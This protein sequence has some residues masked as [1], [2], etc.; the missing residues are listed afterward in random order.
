MLHLLLAQIT[1]WPLAL[2]G[3]LLA[4][5]SSYVSAGFGSDKVT[6]SN[7]EASTV[8]GWIGISNFLHFLAGGGS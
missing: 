1:M 7:Q 8:M 6:T 4:I 3:I 5:I 2:A